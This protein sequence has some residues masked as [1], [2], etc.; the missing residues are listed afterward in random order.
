MNDSN[1]DLVAT[2]P[3]G[4]QIT[5]AS[6]PDGV[7]QNTYY[8]VTSE[9]R[10]GYVDGSY[11]DTRFIQNCS[12]AILEDTQDPRAPPN[13]ISDVRS[14]GRTEVCSRNLAPMISKR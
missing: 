11:E 9:A 1:V 5:Q 12:D 13:V 10:Y 3:D 8:C 2:V 14:N 6:V 7:Y 4:I